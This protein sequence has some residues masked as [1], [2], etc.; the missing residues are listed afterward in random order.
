MMFYCFLT[1]RNT[2]LPQSNLRSMIH[3]LPLLFLQPTL[4]DIIYQLWCAFFVQRNKELGCCVYVCVHPPT[5]SNFEITKWI[6]EKFG[7]F[8]CVC[9]C[10]WSN[11]GGGGHIE[12]SWTKLA[13]TSPIMLESNIINPPPQTSNLQNNCAQSI[14]CTL[15]LSKR[16][17]CKFSLTWYMYI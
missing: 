12:R 3:K 6:E 9:V 15:L 5:C 4:M 17:C 7:I 10:V 1:S 8:V 2:E 11:G 13:C 16:F 14:T